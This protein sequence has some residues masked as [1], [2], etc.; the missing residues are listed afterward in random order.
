[1]TARVPAVAD[2]QWTPQPL[3]LEDLLRHD[4]VVHMSAR[5]AHAGVRVAL[6]PVR[7]PR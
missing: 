3:P 7:R 6:P 1:V 5:L 4:A 2:E